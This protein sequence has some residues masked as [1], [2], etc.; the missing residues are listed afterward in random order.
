MRQSASSIL[1]GIRDE[2]K[3]RLKCF[4]ISGYSSAFENRHFSFYHA[5]IENH[6]QTSTMEYVFLA[7]LEVLRE[8]RINEIFIFI[9]VLLFHF[10]LTHKLKELWKE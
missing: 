9:R 2:C 10:K 8:K 4:S 1:T 5:Y 6:S 3:F 7:L